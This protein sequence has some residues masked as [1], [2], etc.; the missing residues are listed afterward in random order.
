MQAASRNG[1]PREAARTGRRTPSPGPGKPEAS[2][3]D[4]AHRL[5]QKDA[6][7]SL[8]FSHDAVTTAWSTDTQSRNSTNSSV[9]LASSP[10]IP[11][12]RMI[13]KTPIE[14]CTSLTKPHTIRSE[15]NVA[16]H[17][18]SSSLNP[19]WM[20]AVPT[21]TWKRDWEARNHGCS[22]TALRI[23]SSDSL[24]CDFCN[25]TKSMGRAELN[26]SKSWSLST[27]PT[28]S[29]LAGDKGDSSADMR[30]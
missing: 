21:V 13:R 1:A 18:R 16:M 28:L 23:T 15:Q 10:L 26:R 3:L 4:I 17:I 22:G 25:E 6:T 5:R 14:A 19:T 11:I 12:L 9:A 29:R 20:H 7:S 27:V 24:P 2:V 30:A 8:R